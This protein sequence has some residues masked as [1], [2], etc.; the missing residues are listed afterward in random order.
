MPGIV[1]GVE[2]GGRVGGRRCGGGEVAENKI[3]SLPLGRFWK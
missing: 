1:M 2:M 3:K